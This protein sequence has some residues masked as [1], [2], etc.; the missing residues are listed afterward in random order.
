[1][2]LTKRHSCPLRIHGHHIIGDL[3]FHTLPADLLTRRFYA[4][5]V[6]VPYLDLFIAE[7]YEN[8]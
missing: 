5:F 4:R 1:M 2:K 8:H 6:D 3:L 7:D